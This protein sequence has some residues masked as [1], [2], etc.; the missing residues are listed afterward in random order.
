M[1]TKRSLVYSANRD[2]AFNTGSGHI[3]KDYMTMV[4]EKLHFDGKPVLSLGVSVKHRLDH[5][6]MLYFLSYIQIEQVI[7]EN[8]LRVDENFSIYNATLSEVE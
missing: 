5:R 4:F 3:W 1:S 7:Q 2:N 8:L 6:N